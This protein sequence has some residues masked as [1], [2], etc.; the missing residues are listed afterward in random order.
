V[1][2]TFSLGE[3]VADEVGRMRESLPPNGA[4]ALRARTLTPNPS[5]VGEGSYGAGDRDE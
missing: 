4:G 1:S 3:K 2:V 5:P